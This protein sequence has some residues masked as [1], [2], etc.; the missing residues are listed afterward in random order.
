MQI[1]INL[2]NADVT[3]SEN[4]QSQIIPVFKTL[5]NQLQ[6]E[7]KDEE[8]RLRA[9]YKSLLLDAPRNLP[10]NEE[11]FLNRD[12]HLYRMRAHLREMNGTLSILKILTVSP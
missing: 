8:E 6:Q 4:E 3:F 9:F 10:D 5:I 2:A 12:E 11:D 7:L 1:T